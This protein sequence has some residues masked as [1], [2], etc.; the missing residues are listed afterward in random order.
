M[1]QRLVGP[2]VVNAVSLFVTGQA[3]QPQPE[4]PDVR[5]FGNAA[6]QAFVA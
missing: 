6:G 1:V 3:F 4:R 5:G 2:A